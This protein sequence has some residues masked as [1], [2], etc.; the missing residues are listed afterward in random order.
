MAIGDGADGGDNSLSAS[1]EKNGLI[2]ALSEF[3]PPADRYAFKPET[4]KSMDDFSSGNF[5]NFAN[6]YLSASP[7][8]QA[9]IK[10]AFG[11]AQIRIETDGDR[12]KLSSDIPGKNAIQQVLMIDKNGKRQDIIEGLRPG[13]EQD[14][15][16][17]PYEGRTP[18]PNSVTRAYQ[19]RIKSFLQ[20][21]RV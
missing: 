17:F 4:I 8:I 20:T 15:Q 5:S 2:L 6:N 1:N 14:E 21:R 12:V 3:A 7:E 11:Q 9:D 13:R 18:N 19:E 10:K 16:L